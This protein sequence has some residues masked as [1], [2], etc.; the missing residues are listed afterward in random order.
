MSLLR[1][2]SK[3][4]LTE[5][6]AK[7]YLYLLEHGKATAREISENTGIPSTKIYSVLKSLESKGWVRVESVER[8]LKYVP[9]PPEVA[10]QEAVE[11]ELKEREKE[12]KEVAK[13]AILDLSRVTKKG[14]ERPAVSYYG[15][16]AEKVMERIL[17]HCRKV[18]GILHVGREQE[19]KVLELLQNVPNKYL[20]VRSEDESPE[21]EDILSLKADVSIPE[22]FFSLS[23]DEKYLVL[24]KESDEQ[25]Y[26]VLLED[27]VLAKGMEE[28]V[29]YVLEERAKEGS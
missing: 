1:N 17:S 26:V 18:S 12:L 16:S 5:R 10:V 21:D 6:E 19:P 22:T 14:A 23:V 4:G 25:L 13:E 29:R 9:V 27:P 20:V 2:L 15:K 7:A 8:P 11:R 24:G 3:L 28:H